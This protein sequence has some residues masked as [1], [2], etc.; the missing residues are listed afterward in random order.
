MQLCSLGSAQVFW[1][2]EE[3]SRWL[4]SGRVTNFSTQRGPANKCL[5]ESSGKEL[6]L[7]GLGYSWGKGSL[8]GQAK[9]DGKRKIIQAQREINYVSHIGKPTSQV[10][11]YHPLQVISINMLSGASGRV[12]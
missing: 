11:V 3:R 1:R 9:C 7:C 8:G 2:V 12:L 6:N 4:G 10:N 5:R